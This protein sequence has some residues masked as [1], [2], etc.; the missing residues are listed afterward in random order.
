MPKLLFKNEWYEP[1]QPNA[2][3]D[4]AFEAMLL[5]RAAALFPGFMPV[6]FHYRVSN[7][8]GHSSPQLALVDSSYRSWWLV[9]L[10]TGLPPSPEYVRQQVEVLRNARYGLDVINLLVERRL[11]SLLELNGLLEKIHLLRDQRSQLLDV[12]LLWG[13]V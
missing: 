4:T 3:L 7:S 1:L 6:P 10:E 12:L 11:S 2:V 8:A 13:V 9:L 5:E